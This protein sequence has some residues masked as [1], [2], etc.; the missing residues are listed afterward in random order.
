MTTLQYICIA[1]ICAIVLP[2]VIIAIYTVVRYA[3]NKPATTDKQ[4][5]VVHNI[6]IDKVS[7]NLSQAIQIPTL[8]LSATNSNSEP[9]VQF[10]EFLKSTYPAIFDK[11]TVTMVNQLS[12]VIHIE[13]SD[14]SLLSG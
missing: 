10:H 5:L 3:K 12:M 13:G 1:I 8:S 7:R 9:F 14:S 6:D 2:T 11:A 4:Q